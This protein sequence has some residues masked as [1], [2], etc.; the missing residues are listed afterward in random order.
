MD[1]YFEE[2]N[3]NDHQCQHERN[4]PGD[5]PGRP[6]GH[7]DRARAGSG[8]AEGHERGGEPGHGF[9]QAG[10]HFFRRAAGAA[11]RA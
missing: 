1:L 2:E 3:K 11:V 10:L 7:H 5:R 8:T 9:Q 4:N 6:A